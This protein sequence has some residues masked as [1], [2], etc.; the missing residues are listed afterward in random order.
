MEA[1]KGVA[2]PRPPVSHRGCPHGL[3]AGLCH[4]ARPQA[5]WVSPGSGGSDPGMPSPQPPPPSPPLLAPSG[6]P[7]HTHS[8]QTE[9][10]HVAPKP[11]VS[12]PA[13]EAPQPNP[14]SFWGRRDVQGLGAR[15]AGWGSAAGGQMEGLPAK[16]GVIS[17]GSASWSANSQTRS[18]TFGFIFPF[19]PQRRLPA[20]VQLAVW[21]RERVAA[22]TGRG[23]GR[24]TQEGE[25]RGR[26]GREMLPV[27]DLGKGHRR[28]VSEWM[29]G[30]RDRDKTKEH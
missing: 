8:P 30:Q 23:V 17:P 14:P 5:G 16:G 4:L 29:D 27:A 1:Q 12:A 26:G 11:G 2:C 25:G 22:H 15:E 9:G 10:P 3:G 24:E 7:V 18:P 28:G 19:F 6:G 20:G 21:H 13:A